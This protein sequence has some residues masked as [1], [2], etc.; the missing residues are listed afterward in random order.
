MG[1]HGGLNILPQKKWN[2]YGRENRLRVAR[3]EAAHAEEQRQ[4]QEKHGAAERDHRLLLLKQRARYRHGGLA[5]INL[6]TMEGPEI[7]PESVEGLDSI[8]VGQALMQPN[9]SVGTGSQIVGQKRIREVEFD[10]PRKEDAV[11][12]VEG[13]AE[14]RD[15]PSEHLQHVNLFA[16][17]EARAHSRNPERAVEEDVQ[18]ARRGN[19]ETQTSDARFDERF[20]FA[21]GM[22]GAIPWYAR[23]GNITT[24]ASNRK[25]EDPASRKDASVGMADITEWRRRGM[26]ALT[27]SA[28]AHQ[29][30][31]EEIPV[32]GTILLGSVEIL[33][34]K[35]RKLSK[36]SKREKSKSIKE[37]PNKWSKLR[38]E[39][40]KR[41]EEERKRQLQAVRTAMGSGAGTANT[42]SRRYHSS[43]GYGN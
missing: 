3:D 2:V 9:Q 22:N 14:E 24:K 32:G 11:A 26:E 1:G 18:R 10:A 20:G 29:L 21:H 30:D 42:K 34:K 40:L 6:D 12:I 17:E 16:E 36:S 37:D 27:K 33:E 23:N 25:D 31:D 15:M 13:R 43:F 38:E 39:R 5:T 19:P 7:H 28:V 35:H 4:I 41:E 8:A